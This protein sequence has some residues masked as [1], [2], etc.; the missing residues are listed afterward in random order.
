VDF[1][2]SGSPILIPIE[3]R[4]RAFYKNVLVGGLGSEVGIGRSATLWRSLDASKVSLYA[5]QRM[6]FPPP[7]GT[8]IQAGDVV[9]SPILGG[10]EPLPCTYWTTNGSGPPSTSALNPSYAICMGQTGQVHFVQ[11]CVGLSTIRIWACFVEGVEVD[12]QAQFVECFPYAQ[13]KIQDCGNYNR[14]SQPPL[15]R[16]VFA[17]CPQVRVKPALFS[18][19]ITSMEP[20]GS[21]F[22]AMFG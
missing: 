20:G 17:Y 8:L 15:S 1:N 13:F 19:P 10:P 5:A 11:D 7:F 6:S 12:L 22:E 4:W 9:M 18:V 2:P 3:D 16:F 21:Q 14:S